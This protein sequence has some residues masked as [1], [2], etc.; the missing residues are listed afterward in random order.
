MPMFKKVKSI[1]RSQIFK[2]LYK[3]TP[4]IPMSI[5]SLKKLKN[6]LLSDKYLALNLY[7]D[8]F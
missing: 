7:E 8:N 5:S 2:K 1:M 3:L 6:N 4:M